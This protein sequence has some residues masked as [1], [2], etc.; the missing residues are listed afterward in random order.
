MVLPSNYQATQKCAVCSSP[1]SGLFC[2]KDGMSY[3]VCH[4]GRHVFV[5]AMMSHEEVI[6]GY[7]SRDSHHSSELKE[8]WDYSPIKDELVYGPRLD[9]IGKF[10]RPGRLLDIGCSNGSFVYAANRRGWDGCGIEL[11]T[12]SYNLARRHGVEVYNRE[13]SESAFPE[14][15][16]SAVTMWQVLEHVRD[17]KPLV[18][19]IVRVLKPG[20]VFALSTPNIESIGWWLLREDWGAVEPQVHLHLFRPD[21]LSRLVN[22]CGLET[23]SIQ[24][25]DILP[26][27]VKRVLRKLKRSATP[28]TRNVVAAMANSLPEAKVRFIFTARRWLNVPL[29]I[30][31]LGEDIYGFFTK[32]GR[33]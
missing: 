31:G 32:L 15:C 10:T 8:K 11:E 9:K 22:A 30:S 5:E 12:G 28:D 1:E 4:C 20:G 21:G 29:N 6:A 26:A 25:M 7:R 27:T 24:T 13:L 19:E 33:P 16:F 2:R 23:R 14:N 17:P 3:R 18:S